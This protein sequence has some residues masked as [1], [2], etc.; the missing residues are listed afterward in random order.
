MELQSGMTGYA[1]I[2]VLTMW[3]CHT[4]TVTAYAREKELLL[5]IDRRTR[6]IVRPILLT[7]G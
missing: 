4:D 5:M 2:N 7:I 6:S 1:T 3:Q